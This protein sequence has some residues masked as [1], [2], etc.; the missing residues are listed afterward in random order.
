MAPGCSDRDD[1]FIVIGIKIKL[2][3]ILFKLNDFVYSPPIFCIYPCTV[4]GF[5]GP[6]AHDSYYFAFFSIKF[7]MFESKGISCNVIICC[8]SRNTESKTVVSFNSTIG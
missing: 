8:R 5:E 3:R 1:Y 6:S 4:Q 2:C 7:I